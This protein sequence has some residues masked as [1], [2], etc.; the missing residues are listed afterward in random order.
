MQDF[1]NEVSALRP[2]LLRAA[3]QRL[4]NDA[5]A[6]DAVSETIVAALE[7]PGR[8]AGRA[9]V[10]TWLVGI[11]KNKAVD[12]IRRNTRETQLCAGDGGD[13]E[14]DTP[15]PAASATFE[16]PARWG[17]PQACLDRRQFMVQFDACLHAL[18][19]AQARA[20]MLRYWMEEESPDICR[21]LDVTAINLAV[22][23]HRARGRLRAALPAQWAPAAA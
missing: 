5:W 13:D 14:F 17:D 15:E 16:A 3:R 6:E 20:F 2:F 4:R 8:H 19:P 23:L 22:M 1:A 18:P 21:E 12:Q 11:L 9:S 10:K 7:H